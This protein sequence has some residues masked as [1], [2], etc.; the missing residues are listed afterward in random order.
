[1]AN[2][3]DLKALSLSG[4]RYRC[5]EESERFFRRMAHDPDYC[6]EL[7]RRAVLS[8]DEHAWELVYRQYETQV[9]GWVER[10]SLFRALNE[11]ADVYANWAFAKMWMVMTPEKFENFHELQSVLRYLQMCVHSV[12]VDAMRNREL[13]ESLTPAEED[14]EQEEKDL[15]D[16]SQPPL[17]EQ[18]VNRSQSEQLWRWLEE[19]VKSEKERRVIYGS[20]VLALKPAEIYAEYRGT[21]KDVREVYVV[22]ENLIE[23][24]RR[25]R[26]LKSLIQDWM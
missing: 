12:L 15:I 3:N 2:S 6:F 16:E 23:R 26:E 10:H 18:V 1:M 17:E 11:D 4:L 13:A 21:F 22:K 20:F 8:R 9:R 24:L 14:P 5:S 25:D 7:I 19:R